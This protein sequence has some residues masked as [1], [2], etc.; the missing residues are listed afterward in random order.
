LMPAWIQFPL[1]H[2]GRPE[3]TGWLHS[4]WN[5]EPMVV[6]GVVALIAAYLV[7]TGSRNRSAT[8]EQINPVSRGQQFSFVLGALVILIAL[9]P[10]IDDW[11]GHF[12]LLAHMLQHLLLIMLA[13]PLLL[14]GT[15][16]PDHSCVHDLEPDYR[17]LAHAV[18]LRCCAAPGAGAHH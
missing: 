1:L 6:V 9:N 2:A 4:D 3:P 5:P 12:L 16:D 14:F 11:S 8:G 13:M 17:H 15:P 7:F 10:P 18:C